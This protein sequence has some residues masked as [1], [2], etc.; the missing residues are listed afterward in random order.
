MFFCHFDWSGAKWRNHRLLIVSYH[1]NA[2]DF[3]ITLRSSRN[4]RDYKIKQKNNV[5]RQKSDI[6]IQSMKKRLFVFTDINV[7]VFC[8]DVKSSALAI[9]VMTLSAYTFRVEKAPECDVAV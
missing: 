9:A 8:C 7:A 5:R 2:G 4:Y 6:I 1:L 3:S